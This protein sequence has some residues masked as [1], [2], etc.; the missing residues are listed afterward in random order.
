MSLCKVYSILTALAFIPAA[1]AEVDFTKEV[2]PILVRSCTSC[3]TGEK[4]QGGLALNTR[5]EILRGGAGG[6]SVVP[7]N[8]GASLLLQ[9]V[10]GEKL[11]RMPFGRDPLPA[12]EIAILKQWIDEGAKGP[13]GVAPPRWV[14]P[15][16]LRKPVPP[17]AERNIVDAFLHGV[18]GKAVA[19]GVFARRVYLDTWGLLPTPSQL[20]DFEQDQDPRKRE[21]LIDQLLRHNQNYAGHWISFWNDLLRNEDGVVYYGER[22]SITPWLQKALE[23]NTPY[24]RF[25]ATLLNPAKPGDPEGYILGITWRGEVPAA[26]RPP[27]QAAQ[28]SAQTFLGINLKCNSCHDSFI[29][30]WKLKD[31]YGLASFFSPEPLDIVRCDAKT[32]EISAPKF[33]FPELGK[34]KTKG[35]LRDRRAEAARLFTM[36]ENGRLARTLVNRY[37]KVLFGRGIVEPVDDMSVEP[38]NPDLLDG[39]A[40]DFAD[41]GYDLKYLLRTM[42][43]SRAY[44]L[45]SVKEVANPGERFVFRGP[46]RRRLSGEQYVDAIASITG[47]WR[48]KPSNTARETKYV[49]EWEL[50]STPLTRALGRPVR[51][52]VVT[53]RLTQP[54]TLQAVE[55]VNG[56]FLAEWLKE[57]ARKLADAPPPPPVN[58]FDS[59]T[60]RRN[61]VQ[62]D[63]PLKGINELR[64]LVVNIDSYDASRVVPQWKDA[65]FVKGDEIFALEDLLKGLDPE[66]LKLP[67]SLIVKIEGR[68]F[69]RF[70][71]RV[72]VSKESTGSDVGPAIRFFVFDREPDM[73]SLVRVDPRTPVE[74]PKERFTADTLITRIYLHAFQRY[75][76]AD[77]RLIA[78]EILGWKLEAE[79]IEDFLWMILQSPEFQYIL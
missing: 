68:E 20:H 50:K 33:L 24:D 78:N 48:Y 63:I 64:L 47:E 37:W 69:D 49:R 9:R 13:A 44:Q 1:A 22:K 56:R 15:L 10:T 40:A 52:Q 28:N 79:T 19:D 66:S 29:S 57:A 14:A 7:G 6:P 60:V 61:P 54:T 2:H 23:E 62:V 72:Q 4:A 25:V 41:H 59:G 31:A 71:A 65:V 30:S 36:R 38:W 32:G 45:E 18:E 26:E 21:K 67:A 11:P 55:L 39:L 75:P 76:S 5:A 3:H 77:E 35:S 34:V 73:R 12:S 70:Q 17:S 16:Q 58:L 51:D 53:D 74:Q 27:L 8:S 46:A 43:T 42:L